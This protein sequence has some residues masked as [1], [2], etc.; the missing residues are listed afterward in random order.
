[1]QLCWTRIQKVPGILEQENELINTIKL[2]QKSRLLGDNNSLIL[3]ACKTA[4]RAVILLIRLTN[5]GKVG[6]HLLYLFGTDALEKIYKPARLYSISR[7]N[8]KCYLHVPGKQK[9]KHCNVLNIRYQLRWWFFGDISRFKLITGVH[10]Q[11]YL[12]V[13]DITLLP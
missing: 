13:K 1:M 5:L 8:K 4:K 7:R 11:L 3:L 10:I 2:I 9:F 6:L 12:Q